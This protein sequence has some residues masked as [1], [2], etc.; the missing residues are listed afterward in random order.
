MDDE[1]KFYEKDLV[2]FL[3]QVLPRRTLGQLTAAIL[4]ACL[5]VEDPEETF[6][7]DIAQQAVE[8]WMID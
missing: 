3:L 1:T 2:D 7:A 8:N 4:N 5:D 6:V